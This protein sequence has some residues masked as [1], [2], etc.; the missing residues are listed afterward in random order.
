MQTAI[1]KLRKVLRDPSLVVTF[2]KF[3]LKRVAIFAI[4]IISRL[5]WSLTALFS[6]RGVEPAI[7]NLGAG[8][9]TPVDS[10]WGEHTVVGPQLAR[11]KTAYQ[12]KRYLEWRFTQYPL[13]R[14]LMQLYGH[15][16]NEVVLDYGCGPGNDLVGFLTYTNARK[17]IGVDVSLKAL[18]FASRRIALHRIDQDRCELIAISD[19]DDD[20]PLDNDSVDYIYSEGV[21]HHISNPEPKI[22]EFHRILQ[23]GSHA[24]IMVYNADSVWLHLYVAYEQM[25]VRERFRGMDLYEAFAKTTDTEECP[26]SRCYKSEDFSTICRDAGFNTVYVGGYLSKMELRLLKKY[27]QLAIGDERLAGEHRQF[28]KGLT[29]DE[30]GLPQYQG[31]YAGIGGVYRLS[32]ESQ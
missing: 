21:L 26:I 2:G 6:K 19:S 10:F 11:V 13:Y 29:F 16:D 30:N 24:C 18:Q 1:E 15:H 4:D 9:C 8:D 27:L 12:S 32:K 3:A 17:V 14:D 23:P 22:R 31:K 28:L 20:I 7:R 25:I 5:F